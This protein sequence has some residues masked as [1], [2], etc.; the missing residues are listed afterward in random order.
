LATRVERIVADTVALDDQVLGALYLGHEWEM[1]ERERLVA[2]IADRSRQLDWLSLELFALQHE[3]PDYV[4]LCVYGEHTRWRESLAQSY[5]DLATA[6]AFRVEVYELLPCAQRPATTPDRILLG[7]RDSKDAA[8]RRQ[9][10]E[11]RLLAKRIKSTDAPLANI[12]PQAIG[13]A[14][15]I[16]GPGSWLLLQPEQGLHV[17]QEGGAKRRCLVHA[18]QATMSGYQPPFRIDR[19]EG[20]GGQEVRR[21]W[22]PPRKSID[23]R[24]V[25]GK[26]FWTGETLAPELAN[27]I[28]RHLKDRVEDWMGS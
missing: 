21:Q 11:T 16:A 7:D 28:E 2:D 19:R 24:L 14:F 8:K 22:S 25:R 1:E 4:T 27:L 15:C 10:N 5:Y 13:V 17:W 20:I 18:S 3:R 26:L 9:A 6:R 23:D 12:T